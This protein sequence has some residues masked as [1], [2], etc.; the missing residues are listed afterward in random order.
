MCLRERRLGAILV[1]RSATKWVVRT[2]RGSGEWHPDKIGVTRLNHR[3][4][5]QNVAGIA[6]G[7]RAT[8]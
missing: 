1:Q 4:T 6:C 7:L 5:K 2:A 8:R 3:F